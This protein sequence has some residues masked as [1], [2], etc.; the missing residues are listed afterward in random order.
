MEGVRAVRHVERVTGVRRSGSRLVLKKV[1]VIG[2][3][4]AAVALLASAV[5]V[6]ATPLP[7]SVAAPSSRLRQ[8]KQDDA[9]ALLFS[10]MCS[11]C[12]DSARVVSQRRTR[13]DWEDVINKMIEKGAIGSDKD[14]EAVYGYLLLNYGRTYINTATSDELTKILGLSKKDA[15]AI[16]AYRTANGPF[17]DLDAIRK[18]PDIDLK[19]IDERKEA[20]AF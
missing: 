1:P 4:V 17:S 12:H 10:R 7:G 11:D 15:D 5:V 16:V 2:V 13:T 9:G 14:F 6:A 18:V 3:G 8:D 19:K 20:I